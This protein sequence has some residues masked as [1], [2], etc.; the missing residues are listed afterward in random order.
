MVHPATSPPKK[1][2]SPGAIP[3]RRSSPSTSSLICFWTSFATALPSIMD[4]ILYSVLRLKNLYLKRKVCKAV[5]WVLVTWRKPKVNP[6]TAH[7]F[8]AEAHHRS[9]FLVCL[10]VG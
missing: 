4:A 3:H 6:K 7:D 1:T 8:K 9:I 2:P 10:L 5:M